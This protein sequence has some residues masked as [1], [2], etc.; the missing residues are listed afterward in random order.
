MKPSSLHIE[1]G[2]KLARIALVGAALLFTAFQATA[3]A[4]TWYWDTNGS[5]DGASDDNQPTGDWYGPPNPSTN[6]TSDPTGNSPTFWYSN[7][8]NIVFT[9]ADP[10]AYWSD[11]LAYT[12]TAHGIAQVSDI[13]FKDGTCTLTTVAPYYLNKDTPY[14]A[15]MNGGQTAMMN[16]I[17]ASTAG[18]SNGITLCGPGTLV[19]NATNVYQ[20]PTTNEGGILQ[21]GAPQVLPRTSMLVLAGGDTRTNSPYTDGYSDMSPTFATGG[22]SQ[23]LGPLLLTGPYNSQNHQTYTIDFGSGASVLVFADSHLQNWNGIPLTIVNY[24]PEVASL[25]F[26]TNSAGLTSTQLSLVQFQFI[27]SQIPPEK[28]NVPGNIDANGF[29]TPVFPTLSVVPS[30]TNNVTLTWNAINGRYY[31]IQCK[32]SLNDPYWSTNFVKNFLAT[33]TTASFTDT[34]GTNSHRCYRIQLM[35][36]PDAD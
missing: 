16:S 7:R 10:Y 23:T 18:T 12:V 1:P 31:N 9:A 21:L 6:W 3:A 33:N 4:P 29:V 19:L 24:T 17:I 30:G 36:V 14:I 25:R 15:V 13:V 28:V 8:A 34:I 2:T 27:D 26:G 22:Y 11:T 5:N 20:G 32:T 35:P